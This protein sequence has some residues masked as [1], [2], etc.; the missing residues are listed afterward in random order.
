MK[1][2]SMGFLIVR[3][4]RWS[5]LYEIWVATSIVKEKVLQF[6]SEEDRWRG[7]GSFSRRQYRVNLP[8]L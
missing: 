7:D 3:S 5:R 4:C 8:V 2:T 1:R 6:V